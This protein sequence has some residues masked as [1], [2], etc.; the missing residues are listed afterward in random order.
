MHFV[1]YNIH[2]AVGWDGVEDIG[3]I[4]DAVRGADAVVLQEVERHWGPGNPPDQPAALAELLSE[5][6]WVYGPTFDVDASTRD[7]NGR[8]VNRRRQ[9]GIMILSKTPV[10]SCRTLAL[11]KWSYDGKFNM[12]MGALEAVV[13]GA[14]GP[15]RVYGLHLGY[16]ASEE[17]QAQI[18]A[19]LV[20]VRAAPVAGGAWTGPGAYSDRDWSAGQPAPPMPDNAVLLGDFNMRPE[21]PEYA[22]LVAGGAE[23]LG[24]T[25]PAFVDAWLAAGHGAELGHSFI[26]PP[27]RSD[28]ADKRIDYC[29][30]CPALAPKIHAASISRRKAP[31]TSRSGP[32]SRTERRTERRIERRTER[33]SAYSGMRVAAA[34]YT[35]VPWH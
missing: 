18:A 24:A 28:M 10:L 2:Y 9:H 35:A 13:D 1:T 16:L 31:T 23:K 34:P 27:E 14:L 20:M 17:R 11:P 21:A 15:L 8:I 32:N 5:Y 33:L 3:R 29:F 7:A 25:E 6:Y 26:Y 4:A 30:A 12:Q 22:Q 19:L